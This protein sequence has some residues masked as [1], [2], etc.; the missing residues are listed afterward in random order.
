MREVAEALGCSLNTAFSRLYAARKK[1]IDELGL[2]VPEEVWKAMSQE[3]PQRL[4]AIQSAPA[5][6]MPCAR[7]ENVCRMLIVSSAACAHRGGVAAA[8]DRSIRAGRWSLGAKIAIPAIG[9]VGLAVGLA[10]LQS[11][12][13]RRWLRRQESSRR[14]ARE[15]SGGQRFGGRCSACGCRATCIVPEAARPTE[16][17]VPLRHPSAVAA[18]PSAKSAPE[19]PSETELVSRAS[20]P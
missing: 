17:V 7:R 11:P 5:L 9:L 12:P 20:A 3:D 19:L 6:P 15:R 4:S 1:V 10:R 14:V 18:A 2:Q 8:F 13:R 16:A